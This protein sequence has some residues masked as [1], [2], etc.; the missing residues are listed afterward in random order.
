MPPVQG[1]R[2]GLAQPQTCLK[3][4]IN[5]WVIAGLRVLGLTMYLNV[6]N[7]WIE[8]NT[9]E[10]ST[11]ATLELGIICGMDRGDGNFDYYEIGDQDEFVFLI[12]FCRYPKVWRKK[13]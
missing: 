1:G 10:I 12:S 3:G 7:E 13:V 11:P 9:T 8:D 6:T 5:L 4:H 2:L